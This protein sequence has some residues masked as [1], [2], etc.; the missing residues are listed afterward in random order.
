MQGRQLYEYAVVRVVPRVERE[1]FINIGVLLYAHASKKI[2]WRCFLDEKKLLALD[3]EADLQEIRQYI[4]AFV[5][6]CCGGRDGG[7]IGGLDAI[8][9]FR[10]LTAFRS[11]M[12]QT[13][14]VHPGFCT[15]PETELHRL[16]QKLVRSP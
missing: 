16:F 7:P 13:S 1:E 15:D 5:R 4:E 12:L 3:S 14:R 10:W 11:T 2:F 8:S 9:R 6:I